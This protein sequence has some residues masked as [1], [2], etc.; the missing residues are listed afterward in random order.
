[1]LLETSVQKKIRRA[2][3][4]GSFDPCTNGH[5]DIIRRA[6]QQFDEVIVGVLRNSSKTPLFSTDERV[7]ILKE[8]TKGLPGVV[9]KAFDGLL[10]NFVRESEAQ[11]IIRGL[12]AISDFEYELQLTQTNRVLAPDVDTMFLIAGLEYA[13]L[14]STMIKEIAVYGEDISRFVPPVTAEAMRAKLKRIEKQ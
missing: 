12:R 2:V 4:P 7:N 10:V 8:V 14:S 6:S 11:V 5:L 3:Y 9:V 1:M 13:Y